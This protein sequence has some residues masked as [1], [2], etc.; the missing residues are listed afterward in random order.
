[1]RTKIWAHRGFSSEAPENT[2]SAF[3]KA[4]DCGADGI[5]LDVHLCKSGEVVVLHDE[6]IDRTSSGKGLVGDFT[7]DELR[8]FDFSYKQN[9]FAGERIPTLAEVYALIAPS[10]LTIN[11]ELKAGALPEPEMI[12]SLARLEAE[13]GMADR[14]IYSSFNHYSLLM[15]KEAL[16][17]AK[18][19]LLYSCGFAYPWNY[20]H[21]IHADALHPM[22]Q[23]LMIPDYVTES[24]KLGVK[25]HPWTV[26][27]PEAMEKLIR[28]GCDAIITNKPALAMEVR[29]KAEKE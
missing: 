19:G 9:E 15:L 12:A 2:L 8:K 4:I 24:H 5:E 3:K 27:E 22:Q 1:M 28:L 11:V 29:A 16:P 23:N 18:L 10:N 7:L 20:A 17:N 21:G 25:V 14:L 13:Y 26:D 6:R